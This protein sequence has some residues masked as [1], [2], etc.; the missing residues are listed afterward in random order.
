MRWIS[1]KEREPEL[2]QYVLVYATFGNNISPEVRATRW[3]PLY[4]KWELPQAKTTYFLACISEGEIAYS[5][6]AWM[7]LPLSPTEEE[8]DELL[9]KKIRYGK[10]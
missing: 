2:N 10:D 9:L 3:G 7:S 1:V 6:I 5:V 4:W 8:C